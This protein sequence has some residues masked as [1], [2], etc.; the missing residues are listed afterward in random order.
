MKSKTSVLKQS[1][2][3]GEL[4][5]D[6]RKGADPRQARKDFV[7]AICWK[8]RESESTRKSK[9]LFGAAVTAKVVASQRTISRKLSVLE[10]GMEIGPAV[11]GRFGDLGTGNPSKYP[12]GRCW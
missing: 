2:V 9:N 7:G 4:R 10:N 5:S 11:K 1:L 6:A 8:L 12:E 3:R